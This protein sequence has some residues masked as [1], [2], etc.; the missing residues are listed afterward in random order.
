MIYNYDDL[1]FRILTIF[2]ITHDDGYFEVKKRPYA[3]LSYKLSGKAEFEIMNNNFFVKSKDILYIPANTDYKVKY[4]SNRS[5]VI[6]MNDCNYT[7]P[8]CFCFGKKTYIETMFLDLLRLWKKNHSVNQAKACMYNI[9]YNISEEKRLTV[10]EPEFINA[11]EYIKSHCYDV[12]LDI[13]QV[14]CKCYI[15][16][17]K[18]QKLFLRYYGVSPKQYLLK[19]KMDKAFKLLADEHLTIGETAVLCGF[20]DGKYFSRLFHQKFGYPPSM[21]RES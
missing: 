16:R 11:V 14:C 7:N 4:S 18:L 1:Y 13:N 19:L 12:A 17:T 9:L 6:H 10:C 8:E 5:I 15:S 20:K 2:S 21:F 3:A